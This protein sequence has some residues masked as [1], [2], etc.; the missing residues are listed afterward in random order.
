[1]GIEPVPPDLLH[2]KGYGCLSPARKS[3]RGKQVADTGKNYGDGS[4]APN[5]EAELT[6]SYS[7]ENSQ[8]PPDPLVHF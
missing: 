4:R 7:R 8:Q 6:F 5:R 3:P 2:Q 1:M